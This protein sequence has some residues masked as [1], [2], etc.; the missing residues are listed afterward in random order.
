M[1]D[2][3]ADKYYND[4][5]KELGRTTLDTRHKRRD[6]IYTFKII[7]GFEDDDSELFCSI[8]NL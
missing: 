5:L 1:I 4:K 8:G 6:Y 7:K 3:F 2:A